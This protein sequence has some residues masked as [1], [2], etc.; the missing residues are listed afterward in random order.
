MSYVQTGLYLYFY[1]SLLI[2][3]II[4]TEDLINYFSSMYFYCHIGNGEQSSQVE[5]T[6]DNVSKVSRRLS[7]G[8]E[9]N[10]HEWRVDDRSGD[11]WLCATSGRKHI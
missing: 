4:H 7:K 11:Q 1:L 5:E 8:N 2:N 9:E 3:I 6:S 10:D